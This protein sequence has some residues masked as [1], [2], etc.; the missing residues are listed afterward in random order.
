MKESGHPRWIGTDLV[1]L[2][3]VLIW[4]MNFSIM[5]GLYEYFHPLAFTAL[6]FVLAAAALGLVLRWR[7][8][9]LAIERPDLMAVV[10]LGI[11]SNT[12]YQ[13]LFVLGLASTK[14]GNAGLLM[15]TTPVFAYVA[16]VILQRERASRTV[17]GGIFLSMIG[18]AAVSL[19]SA[20]QVSVGAT[21]RG[22]L[23]VLGAAICWGWYTGGAARLIVKYG[24]V[25]LTFW[26]MVAGT[27]AMVP[28]LLPYLIHQ[29][30]LSVPFRGWIGFSYSTFLSIAYCYL[31]WSYALER[32]GVARTAV[33]SN[34]TPLVALI[35]GWL[36]LNERPV[37]GQWIGVA[38]ILTGVFIVRSH[39][40]ALP[41]P[42]AKS[43]GSD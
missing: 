6:R 25:R 4:G 24:A 19:F 3:V 22:D 14:S 5:K 29:D 2:S 1:L 9:P 17:L 32:V 21:W 35:G 31:A 23:M 43:R 12:V 38:L 11:L 27:V 28:L 18:V 40:P 33:F 37:T 34:L 20:Q 16:G 26:V 36:V 15:A 41:I 13:I 42:D 10:S 30:W 7:G 39:K 8:L